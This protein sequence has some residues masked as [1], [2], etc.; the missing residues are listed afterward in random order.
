VALD[1]DVSNTYSFSV[2]SSIAESVATDRFELRFQTSTLG[3]DDFDAEGISVYPNPAS[4]VFN[5]DFG[6]N[7]GRFDSLELFDISGR[8]VAKQAISNQ[9][10]QTQLDVNAFS[11]GV[12]LLKVSSNR[13]QLTTKVIIK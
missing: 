9:L 3:T 1:N 13:E 5:V 7:I 6:P 10:E 12:Y 11:S 2:D 4:N 8:L